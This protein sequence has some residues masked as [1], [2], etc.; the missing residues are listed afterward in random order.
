MAQE[1]TN[2]PRN[3]CTMTLSINLADN[4][5]ASSDVDNCINHIKRLEKKNAKKHRNNLNKLQ[6]Y[7]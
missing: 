5:S 2:N 4:N 7:Y 6:K 3:D 1:T